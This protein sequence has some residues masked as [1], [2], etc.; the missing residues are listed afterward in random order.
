[1]FIGCSKVTLIRA[2]SYNKFNK[3]AI[4]HTLTQ[5]FG[6][7]VF[8]LLELGILVTGFVVLTALQLHLN[9][10]SNIRTLRFPLSSSETSTIS[11]AQTCHLMMFIV[12]QGMCLLN[13]SGFI[14]FCRTLV[15]ALLKRGQL[16]LD[17]VS[18]LRCALTDTWW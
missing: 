18:G 2:S 3:M 4:T 1:M 6:K 8:P 16:L 14:R 15:R 11:K 7:S 13:M 9:N 10:Q 12:I 17:P 5:V